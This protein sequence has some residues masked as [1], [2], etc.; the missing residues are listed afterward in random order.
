MGRAFIRSQSREDGDI[1]GIFFDERRKF[2]Y[3]P[4]S[5][6]GFFA[7]PDSWLNDENFKRHDA[8]TEFRGVPAAVMRTASQ[9]AVL[10]TL[11]AAIAIVEIGLRRLRSGRSESPVWLYSRIAILA[12]LG[13]TFYPVMKA[14]QLGQIQVYLNALTALGILAYQLG[15]RASSGLCLGICCL[16]KPQF[17]VLAIWALLRKRWRML[18]GFMAAVVPV[19]LLSLVMFGWENH[20]R[21]LEVIRD[22]SR[23]G[24]VYWPN[25]SVNGF[26]SRLL[27]N[28]DPEYFSMFEFAPYHPWVHR[29][30]IVTSLAILSLALF[31][32]RPASRAGGELDL[33][34]MIAA[35]TIAS[36]IAWEHHYGAFLPLFALV[37]P[38]CLR[39][40]LPNRRLGLLL[41][42]AFLA[43]GV[44][45]L[46]PD[47]FF[48]P[49]SRGWLASHLFYGAAMFFGQLIYLR[50]RMAV[51]AAAVETVAAEPAPPR[52]NAILTSTEL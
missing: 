29:V 30:T 14:H 22:I 15:W 45:V 48:H 6:L 36:P 42:A 37:L 34:V 51:Q 9:V 39:G 24:E 17:A 11:A 25:Q 47:A 46:A 5:L 21:Y 40:G 32:R 35:A 28:G 27:G 13:L 38:V 19:G 16:V 52:E 43:M 26:L 23:L 33:A 7:V 2:Q 44:A 3:P 12:V 8:V 50:F 1:Y 20:L 31:H 4:T 10:L 49:R 41:A 18:G